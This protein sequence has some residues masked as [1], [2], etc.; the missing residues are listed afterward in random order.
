MF[1][2][3]GFDVWLSNARG[4]LYS[5]RHQ[6]KNPND[7]SSGFWHF[8]WYE[9]AIYDYPA[10]I[11]YVRDETNNSKVFIIGHSQGTTTLMTLL[12]E[13]TEYNQKVAAASLITPV[14]YLNN[15]DSLLHIVSKV[16]L[17]LPVNLSKSQSHFFST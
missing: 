10:V 17:Q 15:S 11:D 4:N 14:G 8:S 1:A 13:K 6:S 2:D 3:A 12:S 9:L 5:R 16:L 7:S